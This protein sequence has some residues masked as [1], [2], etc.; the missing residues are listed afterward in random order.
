M[1]LPPDDDLSKQLGEGVDPMKWLESLAARQ[2][3][4]PD[5]FITSADMDI[6]EADANSVI[7]EPG[8]LD[9]DPFGSSTPAQ[10]DNPS[11]PASAP[12]AASPAPPAVSSL[13]PTEDIDPLAWLESLARRQGAN[14]E[15]FVTEANLEVPE[16]DP[17]TKIDEPG[18]TPYEAAGPSAPSRRAQP[19]PPAPEP[20]PEPVQ[21]VAQEPAAIGEEGDLTLDEAAAILGVS[22]A[23]MAPLAAT[24]AAPAT[25]QPISADPLGGEV[26]PL[27]WLES[28]ARRQGAKSEELITS[29]DLDVPEADADAVIDEPG[30]HDYMGYDET[31]QAAAPAA[32]A[33]PEP[34]PVE[35]EAALPSGEDTLAWLE[36]LAAEQGALPIEDEGQIEALGE[37]DPLAGL[38]DA[39]I[40]LMAA[41]GRLSPDQM[42]AWLSRQADSLAEARASAEGMVSDDALIPAEPGDIPS[43]LQ[44]A[45]PSADAAA[46]L[47]AAAEMPDWLLEDVGEP[48]PDLQEILGE[49]PQ[50]ESETYEDSWAAALDEEYVSQRLG[51]ERDEPEWY[52]EAL[53]NPDRL[54]ALQNAQAAETEAEAEAA[55]PE[56][57]LAAPEQGDL[58]DWLKDAAPSESL[59][60]IGEDVPDWLVEELPETADE[61]ALQDWLTEP[62]AAREAAPQ[63][64]A[65]PEAEAASEDVPELAEAEA[66]ALD[67]LSEPAV[68][69]AVLP[70]WLIEA[71]PEPLAAAPKAEPASAPA[72]PVRQPAAASPAPAAPAPRPTT[73]RALRPT[74]P[75]VPAGEAYAS[76]R[77]RLESDP[78]DHAARLELAR[79]LQSDARMEDSLN[80][81]EALVFD[82][83]LLDNV[84]QDLNTLVEQR[85]D[86]P[87]ALRVLGD[88][89][90]HQGRLQDALEM[91]RAALEQL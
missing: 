89:R 32:A 73:R 23:D 29:A 61:P 6:P 35:A 45:A 51:D 28:L 76:Y 24:P 42:E 88:V 18:Y 12:A 44:E 87:Q 25:A 52:T 17:S 77:N 50:A 1:T 71:A 72:A 49:T 43:W 5:E 10:A 84:E 15:E 27:A 22:P 16:V 21:A 26:D 63:E 79:R 90:L 81:Y 30:Y 11:T 2:G 65:L 14:P 80:H 34:E 70:D 31:P 39:D 78:Q 82:E 37:A 64:A 75:P 36:D 4:N 55:E 20:E 33:P 57:E 91:Y 69:P 54:A 9:Y 3:A 58:P 67:W 85:Q 19:Q 68:E 7:D 56:P 47:E 62:V 74:P 60:A 38:S 53:N 48:Q 66:E 83:A 8:Y 46:E 13:G 86:V 41:E 59:D 40:E